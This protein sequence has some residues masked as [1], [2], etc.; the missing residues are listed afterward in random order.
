MKEKMRRRMR[1]EEMDELRPCPFC[2]N[3]MQ[4]RFGYMS[5]C[6]IS[7]KQYRRIYGVYYQTCT[8]KCNRCGCTIQQAG[9]TNEIAEQ[10]TRNLWNGRTKLYE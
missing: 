5:G 2:G 10:Y 1:G 8:L 3:K 7:F 9:P 4:N 6:T